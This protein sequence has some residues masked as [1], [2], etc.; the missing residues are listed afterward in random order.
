M[1]SEEKRARALRAFT[2]QDYDAAERL[3]LELVEEYPYSWHAH[4]MLGT[5]YTQQR[6]FEKAENSFRT[7][8]KLQPENAEGYNNLAVLYR[9]QDR[10][11]HA[12]ELARTAL[13]FAPERADILYNLGNILKRSGDIDAARAAYSDAIHR[14]PGFVMA[15]NNLG[16]LYEHSGQHPEAVRM[17]EAGLEHDENHPTLRYN[18]GISQL[19]LGRLEDA[20][21]SF[22]RALRS[23]P[24]W[25]DALNNLGIVL[26]RLEEYEE[27]QRVFEEIL[28][29]E[30]ENPRALN[31][32][33]SILSH[34]GKYEE[35]G[36]YLRRSLRR[37]PSYRKAAANLG[38][39]LARTDG[40]GYLEE[41]RKL[42]A[43]SPQNTDLRYQLADLLNRLEHY[44]EAR[45][46]LRE[47]LELEDE[48]IAA[49]QLLAKVAFRLGLNDES[50]D[51]IRILEKQGAATGEFQLEFARIELELQRYTEARQRIQGYLAQHPDDMQAHGLLGEILA[52][53]DKLEEAISHIEQQLKR[54][55]GDAYLLSLLAR[56]ESQRGNKERAM[57]AAEE[58]I[59]LQGN[60]ANPDDISALNESLDLYEDIVSSFQDE[61]AESWQRNIE[62]LGRL[63]ALSGE[64]PAQAQ[65]LEAEY[66]E[67]LEADDAVPILDFEQNF[68]NEDFDIE[69]PEAADEADE[70]IDE[71]PQEWV[72]EYAEAGMPAYAGSPVSGDSSGGGAPQPAA[73][74]LD[75]ESTAAEDRPG[76]L[77]E[78][79]EDAAAA[80][81]G[82]G[83]DADADDAAG[84]AADDGKTAA[85]D[86][87][88]DVT[89]PPQR[90]VSPYPP[91]YPPPQMPP[92]PQS[93]QQP[94]AQAAPMQSYNFV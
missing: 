82:L 5:I 9:H 63:A 55:P 69:A 81:A 72:E 52:A 56:F 86:S 88:P 76:S 42:S 73:E 4:M 44:E 80:D 37:D 10:L 91:Q 16:T 93:Y 31:N 59:S 79:L 15:Y 85:S 26:Q 78:L 62:K 47:L 84:T 27:A 94:P 48:H 49:L 23:R 50:A 8:I 67:N 32:I 39:V 24:G 18:L 33:A 12:L 28:S 60:R 41:L 51:C 89:A 65:E 19:E 46:Q 17:L 75:D 14:D 68:L 36:E 38:Q 11:E 34:L 53:Q 20:R 25:V 40:R 58:L 92:Q 54:Y 29:I 77:M 45:T 66:G 64:R 74:D 6:A 35:A 61:L 71:P 70:E 90:P 1:K 2:L 87:K 22:V 30:S 21:D 7:A 83:Q 3:S 43:L 13:S 57:S